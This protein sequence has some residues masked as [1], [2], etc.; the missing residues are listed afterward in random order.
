[1]SQPPVENSLNATTSKKAKGG[2]LI[3][4]SS[5]M[6]H[7]PDYTIVQ[8]RQPD[9]DCTVGAIGFNAAKNSLGTIAHN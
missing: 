8:P 6:M 7:T 3:Y 9:F 2:S 1:M 5:F 4:G